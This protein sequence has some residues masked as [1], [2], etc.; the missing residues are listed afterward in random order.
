MAKTAATKTTPAAPT[1]GAP[2]PALTPDELTKVIG[3][4]PLELSAAFN[5]ALPDVAVLILTYERPA[6][7]TQTIS[8]LR[9]RLLY[10]AEKLHWFVAD[11]ASPSG[12]DA[13]KADPAFDGVTWLVNDKNEGWGVTVNR[14]LTIIHESFPLVFF[15]EDDYV[16]SQPLE[17]WK[18]VALLA[19]KP[20][21]GMLRYRGTGG[22]MMVYHGLEADISA[23]APTPDWREAAGSYVAG[24]LSYLQL[25]NGSPSPYLYSNGPH[26]RTARFSNWYGLYDEGRTLG[27]TEEAMAV[28]VKSKMIENPNEAP[29]IAI[30]PEFIAMRFEHI[31][32]SRQLTE[33]DKGAGPN[34]PPPESL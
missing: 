34:V 5:P 20:A 3:G 19:A 1:D 13:L 29:A 22:D 26:L 6:E 8:A 2:A 21:I 11:D 14:A 16:L 24:R 31:G 33:A 27:A 32:Q 28:R 10:P 4:E 30:L 18:G 23:L 25:G 17:L 7:L 12:V 15:S 9:E